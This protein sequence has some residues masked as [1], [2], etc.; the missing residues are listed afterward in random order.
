VPR[1]P[2]KASHA[3][4]ILLELEDKIIEPLSSATKPKVQSLIRGTK[5][6]LTYSQL[7]EKD[8]Q[9][10]QARRTEEMQRK[11]NKRKVVQK[12]GGLTL[13]DAE[14]KIAEKER[15]ER[16]KE[17]KKQEQ[18]LKRLE[19]QEKKAMHAKGVLDRRAERVRLKRVRELFQEG[20]EVPPELQVPIEDREKVWLGERAE[21]EAQ[22]A[23]EKVEEEEE[24]EILFIIDTEGDR[25]IVPDLDQDYIPLPSS[26]PLE[27]GSQWYRET[28]VK[29]NRGESDD[30][31]VYR[32][33]DSDDS[34][35]FRG[36]M[37]YSWD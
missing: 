16:E 14:V 1:T 19:R 28:I 11:V 34:E 27:G 4:Q 25:T 15:K 12:H 7:Q 32:E 30:S 6:V 26:P 37:D 10:I 2:T 5:E 22:L 24:E 8:L 18:V 17:N 35:V 21:R 3:E 36:E 13:R 20:Q 31:E 23:R 9:V 33:S 29:G